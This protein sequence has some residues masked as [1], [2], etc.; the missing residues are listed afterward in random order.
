MSHTEQTGAPQPALVNE[1]N[2]EMEL[3]QAVSEALR[4]DPTTARYPIEVT[5]L[6][7]AVTLTGDVASVR[8]RDEAERV[9]RGVPGVGAVLNELVVRVAESEDTDL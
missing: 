8:V 6:S 1:P 9:A 2:G 5:V 7:T 3:R 4:A